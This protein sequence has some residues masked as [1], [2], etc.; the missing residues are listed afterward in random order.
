METDWRPDSW[1]EIVTDNHTKNYGDAGRRCL[2]T[3]ADAML[4]ALRTV[5]SLEGFERMTEVI[6]K[7]S[8]LEVE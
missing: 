4:E 1:E 6:L 5:H 3:G 7:P 2:E 8:L